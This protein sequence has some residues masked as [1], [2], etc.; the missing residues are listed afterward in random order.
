MLGDDQDPPPPRIRLGDLEPAAA[1][2]VFATFD[3]PQR[4]VAP[5]Q[6]RVSYDGHEVVGGGWII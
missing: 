2:E 4:A 1:G 3:E 6:S 5:G